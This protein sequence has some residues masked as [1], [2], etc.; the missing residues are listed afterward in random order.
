MD[1]PIKISVLMLAYN[2]RPYI[3]EAIRSVILQHTHFD[4]ELIIGDDC[5]TD[6]TAERC[7]EW[8]T[9]YPE[10]IILLQGE[11][12]M[13]LARNFIRTYQ[14]A[15]G[16]YIAIC[17]ADDFWTDANKLQ[18]QAD[19]LDSHPEYT[20]CFHRVVNYYEADHSKSLS[21]GRQST[22]M[23]IEDVALCNPITNVSVC[24]RR[25]LFGALP[26]W[27][28]QVTSYDLVMHLLTLQYGPVYYMKRP[29]A[30]YRKLATSIWTGGDKARRA[31]ISRKNR[32]LLMDYFRDRNQQVYDI[33]RR[34]NALNCLDMALYSEAQGQT[35]EADDYLNHLRQYE[36]TW[37]DTDI[38]RE[39][40]C[41]THSQ[42]G[43]RLHTCLTVCR[44]IL[45]RYIPLPRIR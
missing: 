38:A 13:G 42:H 27:M 40:Q 10:R 4:Y 31:L 35:H 6:G 28:N 37:D 39:R 26:E 19:F 18:I 17:E 45:S 34:A 43:S 14:A 8:Q 3:D 2:Q 29:M 22:T 1:N 32:D 21:N 23:T 12:N 30:V 16:T 15:R 5:S 44:R 9:R 24:Y 25:G 33:L 36:P 41:L 7:R 11:T 20:M